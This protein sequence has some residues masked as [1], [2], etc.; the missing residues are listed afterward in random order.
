[1]LPLQEL[2]TLHESIFLT[3]QIQTALFL[4]WYFSLPLGVVLSLPA[5][6]QSSALQRWLQP[7][8]VIPTS[9]GTDEGLD[10]DAAPEAGFTPAEKALRRLS[11]CSHEL[12]AVFSACWRTAKLFHAFILSQHCGWGEVQ[13][14]KH[15]EESTL[16]KFSSVGSGVRWRI[17]EDCIAKTVHLSLRLGKVGRLSAEAVEHVDE[18]MRAVAMMQL[19]SSHEP[20]ENDLTIPQPSRADV[21]AYATDDAAPD[22]WVAE[23]EHCRNMQTMK[24]WSAVLTAF[25]Q[26]SDCDSLCCFRVSVLCAAWNADRSDMHQLEDALLELDALANLKMKTA[27]AVHIWEKY[28]RVHVVTLISFWEES[29]VGRK[30]QRGLQPQV[31]RRF[32]AII[33]SL[34][35]MLSVSAKALLKSSA[36]VQ[37]AAA[38]AGEDDEDEDEDEDEDREVN[39]DIDRPAVA[40]FK[41]SSLTRDSRW[42]CPVGNLRLIFNRRWPPPRDASTLM[43]TLVSF[44]LSKLSLAQVTDHTSLILLLDSFAATAVT[45]VSIVKLFPGHG[46]HL[47]RPHTFVAAAEDETLQAHQRQRELVQKERSAFLKQL[48]RYDDSL[49]FALAEA[50]GLSLETIREEHVV[51]L[52]QSGQ[53]ELGDLWIDK[54]KHP[55][56]IVS[57]LG[58]IARARLAI[59]LQ[60]MKAEAQYAMIMSVLPADVFLWVISNTQ[61]PL[62]ADPLVERLDRAPSLTATHHLL[63]QC[64]SLMPAPEGEDFEKVSA[65]SVLV[66]DVISQVKQQQQQQGLRSSSP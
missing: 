12:G 14:A 22:A 24:D 21:T 58:A 10:G 13:A 15:L 66:K 41:L 47:C 44:D 33:K 40:E 45:P 46:A 60:R 7:A 48:V 4:D 17:L 54:I 65:M 64:L 19:N 62:E 27:M 31:A 53:D 2:Q 36:Q 56:R 38:E 8:L 16:G 25:P 5:P 23:M 42:S 50:F 61:P 57:Q 29:A 28:I 3:P 51:F 35:S 26:L 49:G 32:F 52:Y 59:I 43:R 9:E 63:L 34:L 20:G 18:I 55:E 6:A 37:E 39:L 11:A 30:P 1:M